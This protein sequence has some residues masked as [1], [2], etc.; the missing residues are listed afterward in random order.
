MSKF[1][2]SRLATAGRIP[3]AVRI[4][5]LNRNEAAA[6]LAP[7][8]MPAATPMSWQSSAQIESAGRARTAAEA[9][10]MSAAVGSN[11]PYGA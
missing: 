3:L 10:T 2:A 1:D 8:Y 5:V 4:R 7:T 6:V 9:T 11:M